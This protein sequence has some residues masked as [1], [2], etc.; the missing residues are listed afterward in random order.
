MRALALIPAHNE[1]ASLSA[2]VAELREI[3]SDLHILIVD[4]GSTDGTPRILERLG[5]QWLRFPERLG[6]GSAVR[7]GLRYASQHQYDIVV[8]LDG[9]GQHSA[10]DVD[11]LL[12][13]LEHGRADVVLGSR[14]LKP[15]VARVGLVRVAKRLLAM[16][17]S[18]V[19]GD[20]VTDPTSGFYALGPDA[21]RVLAEHHPTGYPE[22]ELRLLLSRSTLR[23]VEMPVHERPRLCGRTS[24]TPGLVVAAGARVALAMVT[25]PLRDR[26]R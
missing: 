14:Y 11:G 21:I 4:D 25:F 16:C 17:L 2:V 22:P 9:D 5:V 24:L 13:P 19:I 23:V 8:R 10:A 20:T 12:A 15:A 26:V 1:A 7:A 6:I 18:A 3:R